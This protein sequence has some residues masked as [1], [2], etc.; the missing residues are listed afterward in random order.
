MIRQGFKITVVNII[1]NLF[2]IINKIEEKVNNVSEH[3]KFQQR[4][5]TIKRSQME[6]QEKN[7]FNLPYQRCR[8]PSTSLSE[9]WIQQIKKTVTELEVRSIE[10]IQAETQRKKRK[11]RK[12]KTLK[13]Q[14]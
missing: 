12:K 3:E 6:M 8:I 4:N 14:K 13:K 7:F 1:S 9:M 11:S 5:K 2:N 10:I